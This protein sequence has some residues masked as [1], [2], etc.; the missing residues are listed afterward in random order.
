[1]ITVSILTP[2]CQH[3]HRQLLEIIVISQTRPTFSMA[4]GG[5][6]ETHACV[7]VISR[8]N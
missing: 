2:S 7:P 1:M 5:Q 4:R 8:V 3:L 6:L